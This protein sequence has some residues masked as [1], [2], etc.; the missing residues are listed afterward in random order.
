[1]DG[2]RVASSIVGAIGSGSAVIAPGI[3][4]ASA[5]F[6]LGLAIQSQ[7]GTVRG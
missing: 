4:T 5:V 3:N 6:A 7:A 2:N 1:L